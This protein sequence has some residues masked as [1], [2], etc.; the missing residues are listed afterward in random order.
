MSVSIFKH[1]NFGGTAMTLKKGN[2]ATIPIGNDQISSI[3]VEPGFFAYF[4]KDSGFRGPR[5][6]LFGGDYSFVHQWND[7]ISSMEIFE[8]DAELYPMVSFFEHANFGG[9]QQNLAGLGASADYNFP[10]FK[11]DSISSMKVPHGARV[12]LY[13]DSGLRGA[14]REFGPGEYSNL[15]HFGFNDKISS[16]QIIRPDLE[17][18]NIE[19]IN[20]VALPDGNTIGLSDSTVN[21]S[22]I[23]QVNTLTLEREI[24]KSTTRSWSN[25]TLIG[26]TVTTTASVGVEKGPI[27]AEMETSISK[28][29]ENT[30]TIGEEETVSEASTFSKSVAVRIPPHAVGEAKLFMTPKKVRLDAIYTFRLV[31]T[32]STFQQEVAIVIDDF[33][34]GEAKISTRPLEVVEAEEA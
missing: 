24:T 16:V 7:Q 23:E 26:I 4:Y 25:S 19:Y 20:E 13:A 12:I 10:F 27:S 28:T 34:V 6:V 29:L 3:K 15:G 17:L 18:I 32:D 8:H 33:Q 11:N 31:G 30:F 21:H 22:S 9:F 1:A 14:H 5:L 2:Y